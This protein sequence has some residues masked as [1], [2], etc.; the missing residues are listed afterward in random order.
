MDDRTLNLW[1]QIEGF[2][3]RGR[4]QGINRGKPGAPLPPQKG[5]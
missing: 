1:R 4:G 3:R 2:R 5:S